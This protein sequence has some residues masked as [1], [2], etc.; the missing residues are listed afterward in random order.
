VNAAGSWEKE[1]DGSRTLW[2][3]GAD[4]V[5]LL[6]HVHRSYGN[7]RLWYAQTAG[8]VW[9]GYFLTRRRAMLALAGRCDRKKGFGL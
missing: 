7:P 6:G 8:G 4:G 2:R 1:Y 3:P 9:W 5:D